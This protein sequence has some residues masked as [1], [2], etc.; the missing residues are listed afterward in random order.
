MF[1]CS[2]LTTYLRRNFSRLLSDQGQ[3]K[4]VNGIEKLVEDLEFLVYQGWSIIIAFPNHQV[5]VIRAF[6]GYRRVERIQVSVTVGT[7]VAYGDHRA[8]QAAVDRADA[9][10]V[11]LVFVVCQE[12]IVIVGVPHHQVFIIRAVVSNCGVVSIE[13]EVATHIAE[14]CVVLANFPFGRFRSSWGGRRLASCSEGRG[15]RADLPGRIEEPPAPSNN[16]VRASV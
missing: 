9:L 1:W 15:S 5:L 11:D 4:P 16:T 6:I 3:V 13:Q 12:V 14:A 8:K 2:N 7:R 10:G